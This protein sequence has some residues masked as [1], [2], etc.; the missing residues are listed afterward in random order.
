MHRLRIVGG[1]SI[2][3]E[4]PKHLLP[5][6][7]PWEFRAA[8]EYTGCDITSESHLVLPA[9]N[10]SDILDHQSVTSLA[11]QQNQLA[12]FSGSLRGSIL[13]D[14]ARSVVL[15]LH[16]GTRVQDAGAGQCKDGSP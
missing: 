2:R 11:F 5:P 4:V 6:L 8:S 13:A 16:P 9:C 14:L 1:K 12:G 10:F 7:R 3:L 15:D